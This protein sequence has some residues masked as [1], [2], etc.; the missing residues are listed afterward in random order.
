VYADLQTNGVRCFYAP[1]D[2][3]IGDSFRTSIEDSIHVHDKLLLVLSNYSI[4]SDWV[5]TEVEAAF[6]RERREKRTV[7][8]PVRI[9]DAIGSTRQGWAADI[10][11][12]RHIGDFTNW[13]HHDGYTK[14][15]QRL[16]RDLKASD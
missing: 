2:L 8:F 9:D 5:R 4:Q 14:N 6:E 3:K 12:T 1:E 13:K 11:R 16:L 10:R 7:L 15:F